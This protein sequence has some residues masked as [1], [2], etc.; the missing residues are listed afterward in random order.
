MLSENFT[1]SHSGSEIPQYTAI[2]G[3]KLWI[4]VL[5]RQYDTVVLMVQSYRRCPRKEDA[6]CAVHGRP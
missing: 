1:I 2:T 6:D 5:D 4:V 3:A